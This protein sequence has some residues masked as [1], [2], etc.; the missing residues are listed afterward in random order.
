VRA[1]VTGL[2]GVLVGLHLPRLGLSGLAVGSVIACGLLGSAAAALLATFRGDRIG[3]R[4][5]LMLQAGLG[6]L[7][8]AAFALASNPVTLCAAAFVGMLNAGGKD[9]GAALIL[10]QAA[11]PSTT[12]DAG[13]TRAI[14]VYTMLQ[15]VGHALGAVL[16]G[17]P[18]LLSSWAAPGAATAAPALAPDGASRGA[19]LGCAV[20]LLASM[21]LYRGLSA[22]I[23][24]GGGSVG[25]S[26]LAAL[27][28]G[29][30]SI[31]LRVAALFGLDAF[32]G[33]F[34]NTA[35]M[36]WFFFE[37]F[38][39]SDLAVSLIFGAAHGL[40]AVS[41]LGAAWLA[42]RIGLV[43]TMVFTH[44]PSSLLL[45]TVAFAPSFPVAAGLFLLREGLV[46][47][48]V[49]TRQSWVLAVVRPEERT[50]ASG[51]SNLVRLPARAVA[52][53][54]SGALLAGP[55]SWL[56][57]LIA[58]SLKIAYDLLLWRAFHGV[59][60]PEERG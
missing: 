60:P 53:V 54:F 56:P 36:S 1:V 51:I 59:R 42:A 46:E 4:R 45:A 15:D 50:L 27:S 29:S 9:R 14:A 3:R 6:G 48:D 37:R 16:A 43:N 47:M 21:A 10:E 41:H 32:A 24:A 20:A 38:G 30:R 25:E 33:G 5:F 28:P 7:G 8:V 26:S 2:L 23:D 58:A 40:N 31:L 39:A 17:V 11:I 44:I 35:L 12:G 34:V 57:L 49:P 13:R 19:L 55:R 22:R 18:A 52:P